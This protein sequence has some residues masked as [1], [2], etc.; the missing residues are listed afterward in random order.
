MQQSQHQSI[1]E[2]GAAGTQYPAVQRNDDDF[3]QEEEP[4]ALY[5]GRTCSGPHDPEIDCD[6][7]VDLTGEDGQDEE[8]TADGAGHCS[9][10]RRRKPSALESWTR[11]VQHRTRLVS[12]KQPL[13]GSGGKE[14]ARERGS[15]RQQLQQ[16]IEM[17]DEESML[18]SM[19]HYLDEVDSSL[20]GTTRPPVR[21]K[22]HRNVTERNAQRIR[23]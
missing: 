5:T 18:R 16:I 21:H 6:Q 23:F 11:T 8:F 14:P 3:E 17:P 22:S 7:V 4:G 20:P 2:S 15:I 12:K 19:R 10:E 13:V 9:G 1:V